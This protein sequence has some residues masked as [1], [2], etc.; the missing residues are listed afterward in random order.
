MIQQFGHHTSFICSRRILR[1][2]PLAA[3]S[4][5]PGSSQDDGAKAA[6]KKKSAQKEIVLPKS[7]YFRLEDTNN[8]VRQR[9]GQGMGRGPHQEDKG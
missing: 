1:G 3:Q 8:E 9:V 6:D 4:G 7:S 5:G 2:H